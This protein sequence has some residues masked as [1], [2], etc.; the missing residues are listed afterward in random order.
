MGKERIE[1]RQR[2]RHLVNC[3]IENESLSG[4]KRNYDLQNK[5]PVNPNL[6]KFS[7]PQ[8]SYIRFKMSRCMHTSHYGYAEVNDIK[9]LHFHNY[10]IPLQGE[11]TDMDF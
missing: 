11:N 4:K 6:M 2:S 10:Y 8:S 1:M 3:E 5:S 7:K 9:A